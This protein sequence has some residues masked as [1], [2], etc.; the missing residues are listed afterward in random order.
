MKYLRK[1]TALLP[2]SIIRNKVINRKYLV[3]Y[4]RDF[5]FLVLVVQIGVFL[6]VLVILNQKY[7]NMK[8][9][10]NEKVKAEKYWQSVAFQYPN[11]PDILFNAAKSS[12]DAGNSKNAREYIDKA[13]RIDPLF[14][15]AHEL[16]DEMKSF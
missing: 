4:L 1:F 15:K 13:I 9:K 2:K 10:H 6:Q 5:L 11:A 3:V 8:A 12:Y 16:R 7:T 14:V